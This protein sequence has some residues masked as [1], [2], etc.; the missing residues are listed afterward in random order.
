M[1]RRHLPTASM[2]NPRFDMG[3]IEEG[4]TDRS[5]SG[6]NA[7]KRDIDFTTSGRARP[8]WRRVWISSPHGICWLSC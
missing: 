7:A 8:P 6:G 4:A 2:L 5:G 3:R 1:R